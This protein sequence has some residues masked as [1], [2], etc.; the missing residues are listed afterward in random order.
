MNCSCEEVI[1]ESNID[2]IITQVFGWLTGILALVKVFFLTIT[3]L[4]KKYAK[5]ISPVFVVIGIVGAICAIVFGVRINEISIYVRG[6]IM[7]ILSIIICIAKIVFDIE[8]NKQS[9]LKKLELSDI[10]DNCENNIIEKLELLK[11]NNS[12]IDEDITY[13]NDD[14]NIIISNDKI[15]INSIQLDSQNSIIQNIIDYISKE[16]CINT[17]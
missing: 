7:L 14:V 10:N 5:N 9:K 16:K 3:L 12:S 15:V 11:N 4:I 8:Y 6:T 17:L 1:D 13:K 2:Y